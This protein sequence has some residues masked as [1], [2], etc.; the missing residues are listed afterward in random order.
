MPEAVVL[1][2]ASASAVP[3]PTPQHSE[4]ESKPHHLALLGSGV[5][6]YFS[7]IFMLSR[8]YLKRNGVK[9]G[10]P[11]SEKAAYLFGAI[12]IGSGLI[13]AGLAASA[14]AG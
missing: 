7:C 4:L 1:G 14:L 2:E 5:F 3:W 6:V 13:M 8:V 9:V 10:R 11:A 12:W